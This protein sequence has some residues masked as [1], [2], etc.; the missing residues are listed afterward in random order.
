MTDIRHLHHHAQDHNCIVAAL[1]VPRKVRGEWRVSEAS[2]KVCDCLEVPPH[3]RRENDRDHDF[4]KP[5]VRRTLDFRFREKVATLPQ[6][7]VA[8][9]CAARKKRGKNHIKNH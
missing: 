4:T 8:Q 5:R 7:D 2:S 9:R 6:K 1:G 3:I